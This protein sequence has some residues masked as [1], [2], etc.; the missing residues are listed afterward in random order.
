MK[1]FHTSDWHLGRML[2][3]RSLLEDQKWFLNQ[4]FLPAVERE[5]PACVIIA[6]DIYDRQ[7]A[8]TEAIRLFDATLS[9][10]VRL[11]TKVCVIS[12]NH[13]GA[14]RI[15]LLKTALR[16]S[17]IY[18]A[19]ELADAFTPVVLEEEGK[20]LQLF[21]L[22]YFDTAQAR[23]FLKVYLFSEKLIQKIPCVGKAPAPKHFW[24]N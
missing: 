6:G 21:L 18:F 12:G 1:L 15:T 14:D 9:Q 3:G 4:V 5:H 10:L 20:K 16:Q 17:G 22:P 13:D 23:D 8:P 11:G 7:I 2:Y 19:T 24:K